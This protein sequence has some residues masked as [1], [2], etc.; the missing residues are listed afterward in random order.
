MKNSQQL[1][2]SDTEVS[3]FIARKV[4]SMLKKFLLPLCAAGFHEVLEKHSFA[5]FLEIFSKLVAIIC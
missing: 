3:Y 5:V 1:E 2:F 4:K